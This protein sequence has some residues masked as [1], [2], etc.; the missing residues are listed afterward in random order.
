MN[1]IIFRYAVDEALKFLSHLDL[2]RLFHRALR[3]TGLP[4]AYSR[5]FNPHPRLNLAVP[6]PVGVTAA[7]E[8]GDVY[9]TDPVSPEEFMQATRAQLPGGL[10]LTGALRADIAAPSLSA[11]IDAA[12][13]DATWSGPGPGPGLEALQQ[14]LRQLLSRDEI[15]VKRPFRGGKI[16]T[17]D[18][19]PF[20]FEASAHRKDGGEA[21]LSLLLQV[22]SKGGVSPILL[23]QQLGLGEEFARAHLWRLHRRGLYVY[24]GGRVEIPFWTGCESDHG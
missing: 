7:K 23:L 11:L 21:E 5:G 20:I 16:A 9:F 3:R 1:R 14:A 17:A 8:Y 6:L 2:M 10:T 24:S 4:M 18:V 15:A 12:R 19:R 13:Y 22:G